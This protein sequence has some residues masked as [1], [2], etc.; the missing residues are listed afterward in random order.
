MGGAGSHRAGTDHSD[1]AFTWQLMAGVGFE[2][3]PGVELGTRYR[4]QHVND[5]V[6]YNSLGDQQRVPESEAHSFEVTLTW[7]FK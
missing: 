1:N 3:M 5:Y 4:F 6:L 2:V 7:A